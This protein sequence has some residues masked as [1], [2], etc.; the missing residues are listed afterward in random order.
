MA[1]DNFTVAF[2]M[3]RFTEEAMPDPN[4]KEIAAIEEAYEDELKG[5]FKILVANLVSAAVSH[6]TDK[7]CIERFKV[8][9]HLTRRAKEL[10]LNAVANTLVA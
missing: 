2:T 6:D 1:R 5:M 8:G 7:L 3:G 10:A 4:A 9:L